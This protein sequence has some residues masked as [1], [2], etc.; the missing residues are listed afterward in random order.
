MHYLDGMY[1]PGRAPWEPHGVAVGDDLVFPIR[2]AAWT[3]GG[4]VVC[5]NGDRLTARRA[6]ASVIQAMRP[7]NYVPSY[8]PQAVCELVILGQQEARCLTLF[9]AI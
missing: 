2:A 7:F 5:A 8:H 3:H 9:D 4:V 6:P 1:R